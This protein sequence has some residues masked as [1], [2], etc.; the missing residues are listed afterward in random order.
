MLEDFSKFIY[1]IETIY[2]KEI[3]KD[4]VLNYINN[5]YKT[6]LKNNKENVE[7]VILKKNCRAYY[8][9]YG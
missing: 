1:E 6:F 3:N 2:L 9:L 8:Y 5:F 7:S 4:V